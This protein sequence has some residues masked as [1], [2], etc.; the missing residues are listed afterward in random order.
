MHKRIEDTII[1]EGRDLGFSYLYNFHIV[2]SFFR[3]LCKIETMFEKL[4]VA[5]HLVFALH[6]N[7]VQAD[8]LSYFRMHRHSH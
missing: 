2:I 6:A 3:Y 7:V 8:L 1:R 4:C 5:A